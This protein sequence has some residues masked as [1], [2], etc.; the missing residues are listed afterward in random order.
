MQ[1]KGDHHRWWKGCQIQSY[2][3]IVRLNLSNQTI[4]SRW[5]CEQD[6]EKGDFIEA[7]V[8]KLT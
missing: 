5:R 3:L 6:K 8:L 2:P 4:L 1:G 7:S